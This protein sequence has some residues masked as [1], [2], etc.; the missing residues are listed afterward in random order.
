[1]SAVITEPG[2]LTVMADVE[3]RSPE[4][5][6]QRRGIVTASAVGHLVAPSTLKPAANESSRGLAR[7]LAAERITGWTEETFP[8]RE[9]WRGIE[10]EPIARKHY[11]EWVGKVEPCGFMVRDFGG[12]KIGY[13]PDGL[14][15]A[16]SLIE[17][18][19]R[20]PKAHLETVLTNEVPAENMAQ[21]QA[22]LLVSGRSSCDYISWCGGMPMWVIC[23]VPDER[24]FEAILEAVA[25]FERTVEQMC[26]D[27]YEKVAGLPATER[28]ERGEII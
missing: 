11:S 15:G 16:T 9:M 24:W 20:A 7:L 17:I 19:S 14:V 1:M 6:D 26:S 28:I 2:V 27:Y 23:V 22:G 4:W 21:I 13:S 5:Y 8:T 10:D 25:K 12:F 18:K 3:Q